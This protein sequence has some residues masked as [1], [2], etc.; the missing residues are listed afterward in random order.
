[1]HGGN[2]KRKTINRTAL[3]EVQDLPDDILQCKE[4]N[5]HWSQ[6]PATA[7]P[8]F[9]VYVWKRCLS[10]T[11]ERH[12]IVSPLDGSLLDRQYQDPPHWVKIE[13]ATKADFRL[14]LMWR[15]F[16]VLKEASDNGQG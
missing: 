14:E 16:K 9:G 5:H 6:I 13:M 2:L 15:N 3:K 11:K 7:R 10:C 4:G 8:S 12:D 1:M